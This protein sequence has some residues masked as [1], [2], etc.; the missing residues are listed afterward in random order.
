MSSFDRVQDVCRCSATTV[1]EVESAGRTCRVVSRYRTVI[2]IG[3]ARLVERP[4][5]EVDYPSVGTLITPRVEAFAVEVWEEHVLV[6]GIA[7][8]KRLGSPR[9]QYESLPEHDG[10]LKTPVSI[11]SL[12]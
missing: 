4:V 10:S 5:M 11:L 12:R 9:L 1:A 3:G 8:Y 6:P 2:T 7:G